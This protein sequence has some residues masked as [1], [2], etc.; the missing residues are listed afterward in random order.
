MTDFRCHRC[1]RDL[2]LIPHKVDEDGQ[3]WCLRCSAAGPANRERVTD[4]E[5]GGRV[6]RSGTPHRDSQPVAVY[7]RREK[8][9][10]SGPPYDR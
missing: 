6:G 9:M 5:E 7:I 3:R 4:L 8:K 10:T 2:R 1:D